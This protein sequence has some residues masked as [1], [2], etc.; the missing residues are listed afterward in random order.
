[1]VLTLPKYVDTPVRGPGVAS[2]RAHTPSRFEPHIQGLR[3]LAVAS[4][5][6]Y[7]LWPT[8]LTGGYVGV[9]VFFVISGYLIC[10]HLLRE[11]SLTGSIR[12]VQFW[13]RRIRRLIPAALLVLLASAV[14]VV[15]AVPAVG[16]AQNLREIRAAALY[17][18]NWQLVASAIDYLG[19]ENAPT[20]VQHFWSLSAEE[21]FYFLMPL[22]L[23]AATR[24]V[25]S[26]RTIAAA[27]GAVVVSS[28]AYSIYLTAVQ[29]G[30]A[31]FSTGTRAWEFAL[32]GLAA[33]FGGRLTLPRLLRA[34][35]G[36]LGL[37]LIGATVVTYTTATPFPGWTA[38]IPVVGTLLAL[39]FAGEVTGLGPGGLLGSRPMRTIGDWSYSIYLWHWPLVVAAPILLGH[40]AGWKVKVVI[41]VATVAL[42]AVTKRFIE[43][44]WR[45]SGSTARAWPTFAAMLAAVAVV[46]LGTT[47]A[48]Q[49]Q[50]QQTVKGQSALAAVAER[51]LGINAVVNGC[52]KPY[53]VTSS[54]VP[55]AAA[56]DVPWNIGVAASQRCPGQSN[57]SPAVVHACTFND[58]PSPALTVALVG[59]SHADHWIDALH[60]YALNHDWRLITYT[61][62]GCGAIVSGRVT[63]E[64]CRSWS[65]SLE[66]VL[67]SRTDLDAVLFSNYASA[68]EWTEQD[69]TAE[70]RRLGE[71]G[72]VVVPV[73]DVP[74]MSTDQTAPNCVA[75]H[76]HEYDPCSGPVPA[77]SKTAA[78]A[79]AA[80]IPA[81]N[82]NDVLCGGG[83]C[84]S[85][86]GGE[87]VY[88]DEAHLT[89]HFAYSMRDVLGDRVTQAIGRSADAEPSA[90]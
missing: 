26:R 41:L 4:V 40:A 81:V 23:L 79:A 90:P 86:I 74:G 54:V 1:M 33:V 8:R 76:L 73:V 70:W 28:L 88:L 10:G 15:V 65:R 62:E 16:W 11:I 20:L 35:L 50:A 82:V 42:A 66:K 7:H 3:A 43:D 32:G 78:A 51:C 31:Y 84:H 25:K 6:L 80:G 39:C 14:F 24:L 2:Q 21:Q 13:A 63:D 69:A 60:A 61:R 58:P 83:R 49:W 17:V 27:L 5:V 44:R 55:A 67:T 52:V 77:S 19:A 68:E 30:A 18:E 53:A 57:T 75:L 37:A 56:D 12:L 29:P 46:A 48:A 38:L 64:R 22:L 59:D 72:R 36:W 34:V 71:A 89:Y 87:I 45:R 47:G 9:D 85:V